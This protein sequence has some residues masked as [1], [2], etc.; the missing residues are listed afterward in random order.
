MPIPQI[1]A[2]QQDPRSFCLYGTALYGDTFRY[3]FDALSLKKPDIVT[4]GSSRMLQFRERFFRRPFYNLSN[5]VSNLNEGQDV[6]EGILQSPY[7]PKTV[8]FGV[9]FWWFNGSYIPPVPYLPRAKPLH[10]FEGYFLFKPFLWLKEGKITLNDYVS[11]ILRPVRAGPCNIGIQ[12]LK[13]R[14]GFAPDGSQY[15]SVDPNVGIVPATKESPFGEIRQIRTGQD[16]YTYATHAD[17]RHIQRFLHLVE[18]LRKEGIEVIVLL[19][20]FA[21][22]V[23]DALRQEQDH[24]GILTDLPMQL[25][26]AGMSVFD[27]TNPATFGSSDCEFLDGVHPGDIA[28]ARLL[29]WIDAERQHQGLSALGDTLELQRIVEEEGGHATA[30]DPRVTPLHEGDFLHLGC[31]K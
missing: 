14:S 25:R 9:D 7:A 3:K 19:P 21:Q 11:T 28:D 17:P 23:A 24:Y 20:P 8:I 31:K 15:P 6:V 2:L 29:L 22:S 1:L 26:T 10:Q 13:R 5:T 18:Q 27:A 30:F 12:A 4:I 16:R